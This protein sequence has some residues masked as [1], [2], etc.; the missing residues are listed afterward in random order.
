MLMGHLAFDASQSASQATSM[1]LCLGEVISQL[2]ANLMI[3][4]DV[5]QDASDSQ[6]TYCVYYDAKI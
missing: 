1:P 2:V 4:P 6:L 3:L 5:C